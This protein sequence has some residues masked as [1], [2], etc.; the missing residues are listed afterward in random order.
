[1]KQCL[2]S[3]R[4]SHHRFIYR[5]VAVRVK[6]HRLADDI[7]TFSPLLSKKAHLIHSIKKLSVGGLEA[8]YLRKCTRNYNA[9]CI[10]HIVLLKSLG[11]GLCGRHSL[12][13]QRINYS[14]RFLFSH[15][16]PALNLLRYE[17]PP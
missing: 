10:G 12:V 3:L 13:F 6:L 4:K 7:S 2:V 17:R 11:Y 16:T 5:R 9:H 14:F 15:F 8:V 1:M